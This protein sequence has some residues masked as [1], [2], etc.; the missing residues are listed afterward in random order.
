VRGLKQFPRLQVIGE[1]SD[2]RTNLQ[3]CVVR[4]LAIQELPGEEQASV[5]VG[6]HG[7]GTTA[8]PLQLVTIFSCMIGVA[9]TKIRHGASIWTSW[10]DDCHLEIHIKSTGS[11]AS[12]P[13]AI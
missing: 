6:W 13:L 8:Q 9:L 4:A 5:R 10:H 3:D 1:H 2:Y 7:L 12:R 11:S